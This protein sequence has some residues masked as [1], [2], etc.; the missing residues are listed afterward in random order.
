MLSKLK[1]QLIGYII[2]GVLATFSDYIVYNAIIHFSNNYVVAK[3]IS[4]LV[5][6]I[7]AFFYNKHITFKAPDRSHT[8]AIKFFVLY[9]ISLVFNVTINRVGIVLF[10]HLCTLKQSILISFILATMVSMVINFI[11]Q[12]F[13]VFKK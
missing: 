8:E 9:I 2:S 3:S 13:W 10:S 5:G 4:F 1:K 11:G 7:V 12:K 6:T